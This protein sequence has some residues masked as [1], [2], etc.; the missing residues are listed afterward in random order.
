[1]DSSAKLSFD[2]HDIRRIILCIAAGILMSVN[3]RTFVR[4]GG[5][6]PGGISG[7]TVMIQDCFDKFKGIEIP[8][9][10]LYLLL[11]IPPVWIGMKKVGKKFT[12]YSLLTILTVT[13]FT[14]II[15]SHAL[16]YDTLLVSVF[17]GIIN[18]AATA[19]TLAAGASSGGMDFVAVYLSERFGIE[20]Y[21]VVLGFNAVLLSIAGLLFGWDRA[22]YSIIFQYAT[23]QV[24][25][26]LNN[27]Y[28]K[29]TLLIVTD[30]PN[31]I[32]KRL[33]EC[34]RHGATEIRVVGAYEETPRTMI[35]SVIS[36]PE[37][38]T[39]LKY[40]KE[41]DPEAFIN[42]IRTER[43]TGRFYMK[44]ND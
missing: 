44:P 9:G 8:Y 21:S 11:N 25:N 5:L 34:V 23:T 27:R 37:L 10:R 7:L 30:H 14:E 4:T 28:K 17:G 22:L 41:T 15:P 1:M 35:Y 24:I 33:N 20:G 43:V 19:L 26:M 40:L 32:V 42:V 12:L 13:V 36:T 3:L 38:K 6:F 18:G 39:V 16:T 29:N 2:K 31:E